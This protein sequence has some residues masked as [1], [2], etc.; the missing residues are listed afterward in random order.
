[1]AKSNERLKLELQQLRDEMKMVRFEKFSC[2]L[3]FLLIFAVNPWM[4]LALL[5]VI[6]YIG[7]RSSIRYR[8]LKNDISRLTDKFE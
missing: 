5:P 6:A 7:H 3:I 4:S 8:G 1:M 2:Y